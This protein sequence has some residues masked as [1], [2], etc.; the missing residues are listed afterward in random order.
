MRLWTAFKLF[1]WVVGSMLVTIFI[2]QNRGPVRVALPFER[3]FGCGL[4]YLLVISYVLG[5]AS[6][7]AWVFAMRVQGEKKRKHQEKEEAEELLDEE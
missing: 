4:I 5:V 2:L 3:S 6:M 1:L 7:A